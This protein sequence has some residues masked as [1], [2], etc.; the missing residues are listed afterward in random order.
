MDD[1]L[2]QVLAEERWMWRGN[3]KPEERK[4]ELSM[5]ESVVNEDVKVAVKDEKRSAGCKSYWA[6]MTAEERAAEIRRRRAVSNGKRDF[7]APVKR[8][9]E[10]PAVLVEALG[11]EGLRLEL[12]AK[13]SAVECVIGLLHDLRER[14]KGGNSQ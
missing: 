13:L 1:T 4:V 12:A 8:K 11:L 5:Q 3:V 7:K 14:G 10:K 6:R 2:S 9:V